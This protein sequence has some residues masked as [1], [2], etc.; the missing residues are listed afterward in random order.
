MSFQLANRYF[1]RVLVACLLSLLAF[2]A[3]ALADYDRF[4][5][6]DVLSNHADELDSSIALY[7]RGQSHPA[8]EER[9]GEYTSSRR[10]RARRRAADDACQWAMLSALL[11]LQERAVREGGNAVVDIR[12]IYDHNEL[13]DGSEYECEVGRMMAGAA[14]RGRVVKLAD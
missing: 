5:V 13:D 1:H 3:G 8:V 4:P 2:S 6:S 11:A 12:S 9:M 7:F 10:T 14:M